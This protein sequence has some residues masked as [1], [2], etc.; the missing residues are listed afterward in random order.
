MKKITLGT[1][2][3]DLALAQARMVAGALRDAGFAGKI[4]ERI[5]QTSGDRRQDIRLSEFA[6]GADPVVD[7]GVFTKELE[8]ALLA[9]E[10]DAAVHSL[11]DLPSRLAD[12]FGLAAVLPRAPVEDIL[13]VRGEACALADLPTGATVATSSVRRARTVAWRR[14]DL[15]LIDIRGNVPTRLRKLADGRAGD[16][17]LLARAGLQRLGFYKDGASSVQID[18]ASIGCTVLADDDFV[19]AAGQGAVGIETLAGSPAVEVLASINEPQTARQVA[20]ERAFL[21]LLGAGC[22]TPVGVHARFTDDGMELEAVVFDEGDEA[23]APKTGKVH[24]DPDD[25]EGLA[26]TLC[27][28]LSIS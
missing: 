22:D 14:P 15:E 2:G 8:D 16:A 4:E 1:R 25:P 5:I 6:K 18:A 20:A 27:K 19:P 23:A 9:G 28:Q 26:A 3:S 7:K 10:I 24:G 17:T 13:L 21:F 11:K 12:D